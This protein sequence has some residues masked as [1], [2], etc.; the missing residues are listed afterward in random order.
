MTNVRIHKYIVLT[1]H[2]LSCHDQ[3]GRLKII[4][5]LIEMI[6]CLANQKFVSLRIVMAASPTRRKKTS[7]EKE[8]SE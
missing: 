4:S 2:L 1:N 7:R 3:H 6:E 5:H 8:N